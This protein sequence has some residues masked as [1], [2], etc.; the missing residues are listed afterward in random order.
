LF[1]K[2][3]ISAFLEGLKLTSFPQ[4]NQSFFLV[5]FGK[6]LAEIFNV[7]VFKRIL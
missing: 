6:Y 4:E 5:L 3:Q 2:E 1:Y 7:N